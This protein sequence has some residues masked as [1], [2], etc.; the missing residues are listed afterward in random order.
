[1]R[2]AAAVRRLRLAAAWFGLAAALA[3]CGPP[4]DGGAPVDPAVL[5]VAWD[6]GGLPQLYRSATDGSERRA[7]TRAP[8]GITDYAVSPVGETIVYSANREDG[9]LDLWQ[10]GP[11]GRGAEQLLACGGE[12]CSGAVW[13]PDGQRLVYVRQPAEGDG[14]PRLYWLEWPGGA[15]EP[16]FP[17]NAQ[18][19]LLP[20]FSAG[21]EWLAFVR[22]GLLP[23]VVAYPLDG[24]EPVELPGDSGAPVAWHPFDLSFLSSVVLYEGESSLTHLFAVQVETQAIQDISG[25]ATTEDTSPAWSPDGQWVAFARKLARAPVGKQVWLMRE[26]GGEARPLTSDPESNFSNL[27][28]SLDGQQLLVQRFATPG[29]ERPEIWLLEVES[30][31]MSLVAPAGVLPAW[32]P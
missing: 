10:V 14:A 25:A 5:F 12:L 18:S 32:L 2:R 29:G 24:R 30:G 27:S 9:G 15:S 6:D 23:S 8:L 21:G 7:L 13:A 19:G 16:V 28:W 11:D 26:E 20:R 3:S 1:M 4:A 17:D 31:K 22:P